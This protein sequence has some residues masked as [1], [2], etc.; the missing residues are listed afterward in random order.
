MN[1]SLTFSPFLIEKIHK[2]K[3]EKKRKE[4]GQKPGICDKLYK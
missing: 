1:G 2:I 3:K 4:K